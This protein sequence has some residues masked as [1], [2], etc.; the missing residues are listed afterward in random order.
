VVQR[1]AKCRDSGSIMELRDSCSLRYTRVNS[2][3]ADST[4]VAFGHTVMHSHYVLIKIL[5]SGKPSPGRAFTVAM[6][7]HFRGSG[8]SIFVGRFYRHEGV[9]GL[10]SR[11]RIEA[12]E[13]YAGVLILVRIAEPFFAFEVSDSPWWWRRFLAYYTRVSPA[14]RW[15]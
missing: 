7:T 6:R 14:H 5:L 1:N 11:S 10:G 4:T 12:A 2:F 13:I 15:Q 8:V 3:R 9:G